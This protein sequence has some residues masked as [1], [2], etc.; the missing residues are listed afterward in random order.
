MGTDSR[1]GHL[2]HNRGFSSDSHKG[3]L[4][5]R[6]EVP[7]VVPGGRN[8]AFGSRLAGK[9]FGVFDTIGSRGLFHVLEREGNKGAGKTGGK[10]LVSG[11]SA[12]KEWRKKI[13]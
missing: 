3:P 11:K 1:G 12:E 9:G 13:E 2:C 8:R 7:V 5:F 4:L 6:T 10:R